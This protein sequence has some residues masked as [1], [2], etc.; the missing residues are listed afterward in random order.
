MVGTVINEETKEPVPFATIRIVD[1]DD[2]YV[3]DVEGHFLIEN[4]RKG[5]LKIEVSSVGFETNIISIDLEEVTD[6][7]FELTPSHYK[8]RELVVSVPAGKL[9]E[10]SI[11]GV[12]HKSLSFSALGGETSLASAL[13]SIPGVEQISTGAGIGK[14]V[15]RGL[16][17]SRVVVYTQN[18]RLE[19]QQFGDEHGLGEN[20]CWNKSN[21][22]Y[23]GASFTSLRRGCTWGSYLFGRREI[24]QSQRVRRV[25]REPIFNKR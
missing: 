13:S 9:D 1:T 14:P 16:S 2:G 15:V 19:N 8:L 3:S 4:F 24:R 25:H 5:I 11:V 6:L 22:G 23:Q 18:M 7:K 17:G 10:V 12:E 20:P 21:R